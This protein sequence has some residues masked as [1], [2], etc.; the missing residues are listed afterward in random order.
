MD[1]I[2][3]VID[4]V[5]NDNSEIGISYGSDFLIAIGEL[6]SLQK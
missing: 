3:Q 1:S 6:I 4:D 5:T 2:D